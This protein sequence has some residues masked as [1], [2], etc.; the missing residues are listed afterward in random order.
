MIRR[1][2]FEMAAHEYTVRPKRDTREAELGSS[3][4]LK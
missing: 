1:N 3:F 4:N 2:K